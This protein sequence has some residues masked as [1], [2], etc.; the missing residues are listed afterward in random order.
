MTWLVILALVVV[1][2]A[3]LWGALMVV[4]CFFGSLASL[5]DLHDDE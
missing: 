1:G 4:V 3:L 5:D 2:S